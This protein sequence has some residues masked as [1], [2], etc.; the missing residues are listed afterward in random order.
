MAEAGEIWGIRVASDARFG[1]GHVMRCLALAEQWPGRVRLYT[2]PDHPW[3]ARFAERNLIEMREAANDSADQ[4]GAALARG[5]IGGAVID[6]YAFSAEKIVALSRQGWLAEIRDLPG[7]TA[8]TVIYPG[9]EAPQGPLSGPEFILLRKEFAAGNKAARAERQA[10][11]PNRLLI[12]FGARDSVNCS[13]LA[14]EALALMANPPPATLVIGA[15]APHL[16]ELRDRAAMLNVEILTEVTDMIRL[17]SRCSIALGAAGVSLAERLCCGLPS[18]VIT[19]NAEQA[20][21]ARAAGAAGAALWLGRHGEIGP[22]LLAR[23]LQPILADKTGL[24]EMRSKGLDLVDGQGAARC[25][26]LLDKLRAGA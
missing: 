10:A 2:D 4:I 25:A 21:N 6:G 24:S 23:R 15:T 9:L 11:L 19:Q 3:A 22:E 8:P 5:E 13:G 17:Y 1:A 18:L 26:T 7:G 14:L 20:P 12:A 16:A